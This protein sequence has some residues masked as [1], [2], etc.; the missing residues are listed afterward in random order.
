MSHPVLRRAVFEDVD[1]IR[2]LVLAAHARWEGV[3]PRPPQPVRADYGRAFR[4]HRFDLLV[5]NGTLVGLVETVAEGDELLIVNVAVHPDRQGEG[6]GVRLLR[7]ADDLARAGKLKGTRLTTNRLMATNIALYERLGYVREKE[8]E[9]EPGMV[10]VH[11]V[12]SLAP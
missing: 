1:E 7:H 8:T 12:R 2:A 10:A 5:E 4:A 11:M 6:H 3:T 9:S